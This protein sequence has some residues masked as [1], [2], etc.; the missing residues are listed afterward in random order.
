MIHWRDIGVINACITGNNTLV[1]IQYCGDIGNGF[2]DIDSSPCSRV[3]FENDN[4]LYNSFV[5]NII[6]D[7]DISSFYDDRI[8]SC[9]PSCRNGV[10]SCVNLIP[11]IWRHSSLRHHLHIFVYGVFDIG[12]S[13][14]TDLVGVISL[15]N[16][17]GATGIGHTENLDGLIDNAIGSCD[18]S[19]VRK[20]IGGGGACI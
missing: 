3:V 1:R 19:S 20:S 7:G 17:D 11:G 9:R 18:D 8:F 10:I 2:V 14:G 5:R 15:Q 6:I 12:T 13:E 4:P 16:I